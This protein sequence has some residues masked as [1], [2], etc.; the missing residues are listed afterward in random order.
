[1]PPP[2]GEAGHCRYRQ[3]CLNEHWFLS[4]TDAQELVDAWREDYNQVRPHSSLGNM[5]PEEFVQQAL[6]AALHG[7]RHGS[8]GTATTTQRQ[9]QEVCLTG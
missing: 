7:G 5:T 3:E 6:D 9:R 8:N 1:M 4:V 2:V